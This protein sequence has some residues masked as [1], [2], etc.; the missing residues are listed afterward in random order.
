MSPVME[1]EVVVTPEMA[2]IGGEIIWDFAEKCDQN[3]VVDSEDFA[4]Q[5]YI[6]MSKIRQVDVNP[7][8]R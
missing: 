7:D 4:R 6:A 2:K 1:N 3:F 5:V 8:A